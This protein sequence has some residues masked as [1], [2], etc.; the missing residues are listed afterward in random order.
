MDL[1]EIDLGKEGEEYVSYSLTGEK[2]LC[3]KIF[4]GL[5]RGGDVFSPLPAT[6][7]LERAKQFRVGGLTSRRETFAWFGRHVEQLRGR[8]PNGSLVFQDVWARP[9]DFAVPR[10]GMFFDAD[11]VYY[12]LG[13]REINPAAIS[14]TERQITSFSLVAVFCNFSFCAADVSQTTDA[15]QTPI[16]S[17]SVI[18]DIANNTQE[19]FVS[20][21]DQEGLV[22]W[23]RKD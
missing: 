15:S 11:S 23:R 8:T 17:E 19:I 14:L 4:R 12:A 9:R 5:D 13:P 3:S 16:V 6:M 1:K 10:D 22:V 7:S 21:Y 2:G 18:D 20:A